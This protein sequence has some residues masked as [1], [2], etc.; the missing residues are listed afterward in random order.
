MEAG[1]GRC[2][3]CKTTKGSR[4]VGVGGHSCQCGAFHLPSLVC[5][6]LGLL[7]TTGAQMNPPASPKETLSP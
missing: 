2:S 7:V 1:P 4:G 3:V 5:T 6:F